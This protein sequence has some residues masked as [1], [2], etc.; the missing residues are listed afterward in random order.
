VDAGGAER[1]FLPQVP[2][3]NP[4][5]EFALRNPISDASLTRANM[6]VLDGYRATRKGKGMLLMSI[7]AVDR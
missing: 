3:V 4:R 6:A 2:A 7:L 1:P 5:Q